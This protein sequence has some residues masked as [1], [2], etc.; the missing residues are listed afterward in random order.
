MYKKSHSIYFII[1]L[2]LLSS[3]A[4]SFFPYDRSKN[5]IVVYLVELPFW[6][7]F[8]FFKMPK[9]ESSLEAVRKNRFIF[10]VSLGFGTSILFV[11]IGVILALFFSAVA[12]LD[13]VKVL[14]VSFL[15]LHVI[16]I[17]LS[18][19]FFSKEIARLNYFGLDYH[20]KIEG[21]DNEEETLDVSEP[22]KLEIVKMLTVLSLD[23]HVKLGNLKNRYFELSKIYHPDRLNQMKQDDRKIAEKE[24]KRIKKAYEFL[25][26][27]LENGDL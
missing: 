6:I 27:K 18:T 23:A 8:T 10:C 7:L 2:T 20:S 16:S 26:E 24:F 22:D 21:S 4:F 25:K 15:P 3:L 11:I 19:W 1:S 17:A 12:G 5:A 9:A 14:T 13:M